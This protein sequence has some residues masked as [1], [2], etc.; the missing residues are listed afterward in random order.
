LINEQKPNDMNCHKCQAAVDQSA[1]YCHVCGAG[2][3]SETGKPGR[4]SKMG[5]LFIL[6][7]VIFFLVSKL[8]NFIPRLD[9]SLWSI[10]RPVYFF[11][12][13]IWALIPLALA[14]TVR[15]KSW[16]IILIILAGVHALIQIIDSS[17]SLISYV[18][19]PVFYNF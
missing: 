12:D 16:R 15:K 1:N 4:L 11:F 19:D 9:N 2:L 10:A 14:F 8:W 17:W 13:I 6:I 18:S 3:K 7:T 5:D